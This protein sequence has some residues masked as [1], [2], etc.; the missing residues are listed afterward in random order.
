MTLAEAQR[1]YQVALENARSAREQAATYVTFEDDAQAARAELI[2]A[3]R[4]LD[5]AYLK[6]MA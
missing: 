3:K 6:A 1:Q 2:D 5:V 4:A